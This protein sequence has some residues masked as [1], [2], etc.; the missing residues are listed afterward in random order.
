NVAASAV[1]GITPFE[2]LEDDG[3]TDIHGSVTSYS[4]TPTPVTATPEPGTFALFASGLMGLAALR[5]RFQRGP[6]ANATTYKASCYS[7]P[8]RKAR[9]LRTPRSRLD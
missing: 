5:R 7:H 2:L 4:Y 8:S 1:P 6:A 9:R 3:V